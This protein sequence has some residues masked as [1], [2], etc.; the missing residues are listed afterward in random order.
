MANI[1]IWHSGLDYSLDLHR[2]PVE[3]LVAGEGSDWS[4][5]RSIETRVGARL[6]YRNHESSIDGRVPHSTINFG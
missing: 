4:G 1:G 5:E 3:V 6:A 2:P